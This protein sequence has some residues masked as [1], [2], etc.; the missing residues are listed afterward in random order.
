MQESIFDIFGTQVKPQQPTIIPSSSSNFQ[1]LKG[2]WVD[3][4][5]DCYNGLVL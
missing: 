3:I 1:A 2:R 4:F 5:S